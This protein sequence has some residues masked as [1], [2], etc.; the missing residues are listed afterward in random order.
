MIKAFCSRSNKFL[1]WEWRK[2]FSV[3]ASRYQ[4]RYQINTNNTKTSTV[5]I[6][7]ALEKLSDELEI[8]IF[9]FTCSKSKKL[10]WLGF[11]FRTAMKSIT[12]LL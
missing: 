1:G 5:T 6:E 2:Q 12:M 9:L 11:G 8:L 10:L 7:L 3:V 4:P